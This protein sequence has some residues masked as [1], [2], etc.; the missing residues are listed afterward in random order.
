MP[1][2]TVSFAFLL[3]FAAAIVPGLS[4]A[5]MREV[6]PAHASH[7]VEGLWNHDTLVSSNGK[8]IPLDGLFLFHDGV[9]IEQAVMGTP[10]SPGTEAM[11]HT[12]PFTKTAEGVALTAEQQIALAP[13]TATASAFRADQ[14]HLLKAENTGDH[15]TLTFGSGTVQTFTR[16]P[17][18]HLRAYAFAEG[19]LVLAD[20]RFLLVAGTPEGSVSGYGLYDRTG[21]TLT[22]HAKRWAVSDEAS[23]EIRADALITA[24]FDGTTLDLG[25]GHRFTVM[26]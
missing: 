19:R 4:Q 5:Q 22:L 10:G 25:D 8:D 17:V 26:P 18:R 23:A 16:I 15:L 1:R 12:G 9:F 11:A 20:T 14:H 6:A 3:A 21:D 24:R 13:A 2:T 7:E